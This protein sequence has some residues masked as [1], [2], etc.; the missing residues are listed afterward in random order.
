[1]IWIIAAVLSLGLGLGLNYARNFILTALAYKAKVLCS[2]VF[3]SRRSPQALLSE[4]LA[5]EDLAAL[6]FIDT[7][8]D[9]A[10]RQVS[11]SF[12][13]LLRQ[14][15][16]YRGEWGCRLVFDSAEALPGQEIPASPAFDFAEDRLIKMEMPR[17]PDTRLDTVLDWAFA[18]PDPKHTRR[19]RAVVVVK[20]GEIV[21]ERYAP[22]FDADMP[23]PGWSLA[24]SVMNALVGIL[25]GQG[26]LDLAAPAPLAEWQ[27][28]AR[29]AITL[30]QLL[31]MSSGLAFAEKAGE[32]GDVTRMLMREPDAAAFALAKPLIAKPGARWA[33]ASGTTN[34]LSRILRQRLG[35]AVYREFPRRALFGPLGMDSA[36]LEADAAGTFVAS[37]FLYATARDWAKFGQLYLQDGVWQG[38]RLL[39]AGWAAYS[40][41]PTPHSDGRY[42]A[43]FWLDI[44]QEYRLTDPGEPL[45]PGAFHAIGYE[46]QCVSI[47]P[48]HNL[49]VVRLGLTRTA[50]AWR[51]DRF[52][53]RIIHA[54]AAPG[55]A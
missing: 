12:F 42:A 17:K 16:V 54:L 49:V 28:D 41:T 3:V 2:G 36:V 55:G 25:V 8:I 43:H 24:K 19:S 7:E 11:A 9:F 10:R 32:L 50:S 27:G 31:R 14:E 47:V 5:I 44:A 6:R 39:P 38:K 45:P 51:Q 23:L 37:S 21:A 34:I 15:A 22:G 20:D 30:E 48:S 33:Y 13:G 53:Q 46:G 40:A 1:M 18:E 26:V 52:I 29:R 35:E 4:D